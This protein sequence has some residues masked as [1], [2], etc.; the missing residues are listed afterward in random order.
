MGRKGKVEYGSSHLDPET[1]MYLINAYMVGKTRERSGEDPLGVDTEL[2]KEALEELK[3]LK[4]YSEDG[5]YTST[6][7]DNMNDFNVGHTAMCVNGVSA[8]FLLTPI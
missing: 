4:K 2:F 6:Y 1:S 5:D 8:G 3:K 7:L